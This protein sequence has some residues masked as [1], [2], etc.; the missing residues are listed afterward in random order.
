MVNFL[1]CIFNDKK[2][3]KN[4]RERK[5]KKKQMMLKKRTVHFCH[6][7]DYSVNSWNH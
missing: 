1:L 3:Q 5:E 7:L 6:F 2:A 4:K